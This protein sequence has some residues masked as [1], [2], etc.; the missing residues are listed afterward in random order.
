MKEVNLNNL[1]YYWRVYFFVLPSLLLVLLFSY[2]P[3]FSAVFHSFFAWDG[4]VTKQFIGLK[5]FSRVLHDPVLMHGFFVI[6]I[7]ILANLVKMIPS[8]VTAVVIHR[9]SSGRWSYIYRVLFVIPMI[10]PTMVTLLIWKF[11]FD[12][13]FGL[14]NDFLEFTHLLD[15]LCWVDAAL[16]WEIFHEGIRP[17]WLAQRELIIPS[18]ILW[19]FPW[20]GVVGVLIY[21]AGLSGINQDVYDAAKIDGTGPFRLFWYVELPLILTQVRLNLVLMI[22]NTLQDY[23]L[24]LVILGI[25]GGPGGAGMLPGLY[26]FRKAFLDQEAG[27]ACAIGLIIFFI[28]LGLTYI[29]QKYVRIDK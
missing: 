15:L 11:F 19:A 26:M 20:V 1:R 25:S 10:I 14:L 6:G 5:N 28:I 12:P 3:A 21:L 4:S 29:N 13:G 8:I 24:V 16:G 7:L 17:A 22:I 18:L 27:Y 23:G 9:L 2:Y